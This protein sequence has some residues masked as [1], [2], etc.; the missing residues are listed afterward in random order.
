MK[1]KYL[2]FFLY[3]I[4]FLTF[5][6]L[7]ANYEN[8]ILVKIENELI[9]TYEVKNKILSNLILSNKKINQKNIDQQKKQALDSLIQ[10]KIKKIELFKY[11]FEDDND[12]INNYLNAISSNN[13]DDLKK[14]FSENDLNFDLYLEE[15]KTQFKWQKLIYKKYAKEISIDDNSINLE[16]EKIMKNK[17]NLEEYNLSEIEILLSNN[18]IDEQ[19]IL[20]I[21]EQINQNGFE[22]TASKFS[23]SSTASNNGKIGWLHA[24][25]LSKEIFNII[26]LM[27]IG[28]VTKP[29]KRKN[30]VIFLKLNDKRISKVENLNLTELKKNIVNKKTSELFRLYSIS[31][32]SM[33]KNTVLIE[34]L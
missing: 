28:E 22:I 4:N 21:S 24:N 25:S 29:I 7:L 1:L 15:I 18:T 14:K 30:S 33:L 6:N 23:D 8:K 19:K 17:I 10:F 31:Y 5:Q 12:Q 34:Y 9:T 13:I 3:L 27:S 11:N 2:I 20:N 16:I 26:K 32:L